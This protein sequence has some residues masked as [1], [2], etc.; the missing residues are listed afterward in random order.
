MPRHA[1]LIAVLDQLRAELT[2][3][4]DV[5]VAYFDALVDNGLTR[6]E[7]LELVVEFQHPYFAPLDEDA[8]DAA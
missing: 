1:G 6:D 2:D 4:A 3:L 7:A 5:V 8:G